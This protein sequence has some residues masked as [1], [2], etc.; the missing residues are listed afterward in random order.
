MAEADTPGPLSLKP[1]DP[2]HDVVEKCKNGKLHR[3]VD[4]VYVVLRLTLDGD[5]IDGDVVAYSY[6]PDFG[7]TFVEQIACRQLYQRFWDYDKEGSPCFDPY[8]DD[9]ELR[10]FPSGRFMM[11]DAAD[12]GDDEHGMPRRVCPTLTL[13]GDGPEHKPFMRYKVCTA[14]LNIYDLMSIETEGDRFFT[15]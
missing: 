7:S 3:P 5:D 8:N 2:A 4:D 6:N 13:Y 10:K 12:D 14:S 1:D 11:W 9:G 15:R